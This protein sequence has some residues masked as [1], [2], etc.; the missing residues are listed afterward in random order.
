M[1]NI[2]SLLGTDAPSASRILINANFDA[3]KLYVENIENN[4]GINSST[5]VIDVSAGSVGII[6]AKGVSSNKMSFPLT[7]T[8]LITLNDALDGKI[9]S[10]SL[11]TKNITADTVTIGNILT[12]NASSNFNSI[13]TFGSPTQHSYVGFNDG[14]NYNITDNISAAPDDAIHTVLYTERVVLLAFLAASKKYT[15]NPDESGLTINLNKG[16]VI[17][18]LNKGGFDFNIDPANIFGSFAGITLKANRASS[19]TLIYEGINSA[20]IKWSVLSS[21][22]VIF[23]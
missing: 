4:L 9:T 23:A 8:S 21:S 13:V 2:N 11:A 15:I 16:H 22:N 14:I 3:L 5:G 20:T 19:I 17:T 1:I 10:V 12:V 7:G 6:K 18:I